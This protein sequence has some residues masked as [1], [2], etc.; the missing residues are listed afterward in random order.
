MMGGEGEGVGNDY[1][2]DEGKG[3]ILPGSY[4]NRGKERLMWEAKYS[5]SL[6]IRRAIEPESRRSR[7]WRSTPEA[8]S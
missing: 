1:G 5:R 7:F 2:D 8:G 3:E 4:E 6:E